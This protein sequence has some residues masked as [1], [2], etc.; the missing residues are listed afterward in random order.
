VS[1]KGSMIMAYV[2]II[3]RVLSSVL[4]AVIVR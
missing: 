2:P 3:E 4:A 1:I